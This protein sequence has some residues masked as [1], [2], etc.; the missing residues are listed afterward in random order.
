MQ[1]STSSY[2]PLTPSVVPNHMLA[3]RP[4]AMATRAAA[5][6]ALTSGPAAAAEGDAVGTDVGAGVG[7]D[8][9]ASVLEC[10]MA[11]A[12]VSSLV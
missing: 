2:I 7:I 1:S 6:C 9:L 8:V 12:L 3:T 10:A 4:P 5:E 11:S